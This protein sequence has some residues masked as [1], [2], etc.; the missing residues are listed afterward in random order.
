MKKILIVAAAAGLMSVAACTSS[1]NTTEVNA[2][3]KIFTA[4]DEKT[5]EDYITGR[6]G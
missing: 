1:N 5:T 6:F 3:E 2:T 4:P